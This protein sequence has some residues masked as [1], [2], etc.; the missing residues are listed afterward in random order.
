MIAKILGLALAGG[1]GSL[2][3]YW[4]SGVVQRQVTVEFPLGTAVVNMAGC[5]L[6]GLVW[7]FAENHLSVSSQWRAVIFVGFFGAFTTFSSFAF[8]TSQLM[9]GSEWMWAVGNLVLQNVCGLM[10]VLAGLAVGRYI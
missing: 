8:E 3:R 7:A 2:A 6:F 10:A 1:C 4:L 5:L 9:I